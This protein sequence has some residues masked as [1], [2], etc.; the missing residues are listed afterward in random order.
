MASEDPIHDV[1]KAVGF[2][3]ETGEWNMSARMFRQRCSI[4]TDLGYSSWSITFL[5]DDS[6][7]SLRASSSYYRISVDQ[8]E[9]ERLKYHICGH[10][11]GEA[12]TICQSCFGIIEEHTHFRIG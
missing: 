5:F 9:D 7:S 8:L 6:A 3:L 2:P 4:S 1:P 10:K 12:I 11:T